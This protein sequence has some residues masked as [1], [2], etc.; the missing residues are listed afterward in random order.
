MIINAPPIFSYPLTRYSLSS[1]AGAGRCWQAV[2]AVSGWLGQAW[3]IAGSVYQFMAAFSVL[4]WQ[5]EADGAV[6]CVHAPTGSAVTLRADG[7]IDFAPARHL[8]LKPK[9]YTLLS[10]DCEALDSQQAP[11]RAE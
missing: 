11:A 3:A 2:F 6:T 8:F 10:A 5:L 9:G 1:W 4:R 7:N